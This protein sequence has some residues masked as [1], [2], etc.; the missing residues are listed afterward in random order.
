MSR[1]ALLLDKDGVINVDHGYVCTPERTDFIEGIFDLCRAAT[2]RDF[3]NIV[4][5]NQAGIARGYY[6]EGEFLAYM[7]WI[8][9]EFRARCAQIDAVYYCPH[10]PVH[11]R[12]AYLRKCDCRKPNPGMILRASRDLGLDLTRSVML[13]DTASDSAA[14]EAAGVGV[15][16]ELPL[17]PP[18]GRPPV[19]LNEMAVCR[20]L[21]AL[22]R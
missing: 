10:H 15:C 16:V 4:V 7:D 5:T 14:G 12:G 20:V 1:R 2:Q 9:G 11:G 21:D 19:A 3:L 13:G 18:G 22:D 8:R 17:I 6:T